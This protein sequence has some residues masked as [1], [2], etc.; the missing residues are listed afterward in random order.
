MNKEMG[1]MGLLLGSRGK[2][3]SVERGQFRKS[4]RRKSER[5]TKHI[6]VIPEKGG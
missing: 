5:E 2:M 6:E 4:C 1:V 3:P